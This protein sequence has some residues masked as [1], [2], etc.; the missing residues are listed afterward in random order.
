MFFFVL[1]GTHL[2]ILTLGWSTIW[3]RRYIFYL[4][5]YNTY[6]LIK[7]PVN[8]K[9]TAYYPSPGI[10]STAARYYLQFPQDRENQ[11]NQGGDTHPGSSGR[12]RGNV[13]QSLH[14]LQI[15]AP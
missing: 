7:K 2:A 9:Q 14:R 10:Y 4:E 13:H 12:K 6:E 1:R 8:Q 15:Q 5:C 3:A 11:A